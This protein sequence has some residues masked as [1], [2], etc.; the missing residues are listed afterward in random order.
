MVETLRDPK[1]WLFALFA[2]F[3][4]VPAGLINQRQII[5]RS[6]GFTMLETL[7]CRLPPESRMEVHG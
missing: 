3:A 7:V 4:M 5:V 2:A 6:F 1:M